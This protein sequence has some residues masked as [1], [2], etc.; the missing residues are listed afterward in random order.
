MG[1]RGKYIPTYAFP[2]PQPGKRPYFRTYDATIS[3]LGQLPSLSVQNRF[4]NRLSSLERSRRTLA[5]AFAEAL[6]K[7]ATSPQLLNFRKNATTFDINFLCRGCNIS[8][9]ENY[10]C[11]AARALSDRHWIEERLVV[12]HDEIQFFSLDKQK[13]RFRISFENVERI[14][15]LPSDQQPVGTTF[16]YMF[17]ESFGRTTYIMVETDDIA[18]A[19]LRSIQN[20]LDRIGDSDDSTGARRLVHVDDPW[21]E[22]LQKST[23]W[24]CNK[25]RIL[26]CRR[27]GFQSHLDTT[28]LQTLSRA[29][30]ALARGLALDPND[31]NDTVR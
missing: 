24:D 15:K 27:F 10:A 20:R 17:L 9:N 7:D 26:N 3:M 31:P 19:T 18:N 11:I 21:N 30:K 23:Q 14:G 29:E 4:S 12:A 28:P 25:R 2:N 22:F 5:M 13:Q 1:K 6:F 8:S 16:S